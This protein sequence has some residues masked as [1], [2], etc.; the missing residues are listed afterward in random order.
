MLMGRGQERPACWPGPARIDVSNPRMF[1][2]STHLSI[3]PC[4][5]PRGPF[6]SACLLLLSSCPSS[7]P[8]HFLSFHLFIFPPTLPSIS[9]S[10]HPAFYQ[11]KTI[12]CPFIYSPDILS[13]HLIHPAFHPSNAFCIF[14]S[15][16]PPIYLPFISCILH[17]LLGY[18]FSN[19]IV[20]HLTG[21]HSVLSFPLHWGPGR[22]TPS[23]EN[24]FASGSGREARMC[25]GVGTADEVEWGCVGGGVLQG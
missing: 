23:L 1:H 22:I 10:I 15:S 12:F 14:L 20:P 24:S 13:F 9:L 25:P 6:C 7:F 18:P 21:Y 17:P 8:P 3:H 11:F 19:A 16:L 5:L 4:P 2:S